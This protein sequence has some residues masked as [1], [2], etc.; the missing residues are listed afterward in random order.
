MKR[1]T[2]LTIDLGSGTGPRQTL[3]LNPPPMTGPMGVSVSL[4]GQAQTPPTLQL[5]DGL[6]KLGEV[7]GFGQPLHLVLP[8]PQVLDARVGWSGWSEDLEVRVAYVA[9]TDGAAPLLPGVTL[10]LRTGGAAT[11]ALQAG[12]RVTL[13]ATGQA[14]VYRDALKVGELT[15]SQGLDVTGPG[16]ITVRAAETLALTREISAQP[17]GPAPPPP[18][19][20][21]PLPNE[22]I[23]VSPELP[24]RFVVPVPAGAC[25]EIELDAELPCGANLLDPQGRAVAGTTVRAGLQTL[26]LPLTVAGDYLLSLAAPAEAEVGVACMVALP[27]EPGEYRIQSDGEHHGWLLT[28]QAGDVLGMQ[29]MRPE[30]AVDRP[31]LLI[32]DRGGTLLAHSAYRTHITAAAPADGTYLLR[33]NYDAAPYTDVTLFLTRE[34]PDDFPQTP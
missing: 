16:L 25:L 10:P 7:R 30:G 4:H 33:A 28:A 6:R 20:P 9:G 34:V 32:A 29:V 18:P 26:T 13:T 17:P 8:S 12:E 21:L 31:R 24:V 1:L 14:A 5:F 23:V 3:S 27:A 15:A 11:L 22:A 19:G 2:E